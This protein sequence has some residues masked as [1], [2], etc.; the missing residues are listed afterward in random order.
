[1]L[2][3]N[4][5]ASPAKRDNEIAIQ[6]YNEIIWNKNTLVSTASDDKRAWEINM[7]KLKMRMVNRNKRS[8]SQ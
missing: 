1:M 2:P 4:A 5:V 8:Y 7:V 3:P 6:D